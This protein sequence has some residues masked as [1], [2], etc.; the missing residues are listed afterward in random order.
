MERMPISSLWHRYTVN[1]SALSPPEFLVVLCCVRS[2]SQLVATPL[3]DF[4]IRRT[5]VMD[6]KFGFGSAEGKEPLL[7]AENRDL[8]LRNA[9]AQLKLRC[10]ELITLNPSMCR[11]CGY[12]KQ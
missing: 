11:V 3:S 4:I 10:S 7:T 12:A 8:W 9:E 6:L 1:S 2:L 5:G